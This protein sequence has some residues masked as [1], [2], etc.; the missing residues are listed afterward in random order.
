MVSCKVKNE[1]LLTQNLQRFWDLNLLGI[2]ENERSVY[3]NVA[4]EIKLEGNRYTL[5]LPF[6]EDHPVTPKNYLWSAKRLKRI[7]HHIVRPPPPPPLPPF[8]KGGGLTSSN[9]AMRVE[10]KYFF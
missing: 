9:L 3:E 4:D 5:K 6:K 10:I 8:Y 2:K 1:D 7:K